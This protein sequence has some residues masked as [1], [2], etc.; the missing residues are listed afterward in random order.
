MNELI[1]TDA[2]LPVR[3]GSSSADA[4]LS[5]CSDIEAVSAWL[6]ARGSRTPNTFDAYKRESG[7]LLLWLKD[8]GLGLRDLKVEHVHEFFQFLAAP[9][10]HWLR[11]RK[12]ERGQQL[13]PTQVMVGPLT[14][15]SIDYARTVLGQMCGYL[16][17]AGY[18]QRNVFRLSS[19][20][21]VVNKS[22]S[23]RS[24]DIESWNWLWSWITRMP[25]EDD[26]EEA[27]AV[28]A[29]WLFALLYHAGIRRD[30]VASGTM[31]DFVRTDGDWQ[32]RVIGKGS[33]ERLVTVN[34]VLLQ[35]LLIY[36]AW[37]GLAP[38][39]PVPS[40]RTPL[41]LSVY[42]ARSAAAMTPRA[43]G[44]IISEVAAEAAKHCADEHI[45]DKIERMS[46]HWM[47]HT[48]ATHR[49]KAGASLQTVQ[50][51][52]GHRDLKTT[53]IYTV[54]IAEARREDAELLARL[55]SGDS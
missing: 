37:H 22:V 28:R 6:L 38:A 48:S 21:A 16:Q 24:L 25:R 26:R 54:D 33:R 27:R 55:H 49:L 19:K 18:V 35:E 32:L 46:T 52:L 5:A 31:G 10:Q 1:D 3:T 23:S 11:P 44:K 14:A 45:R 17:D 15:S 20:P 40:E 51:E 4:A 9:P 2:S 7:R 30:E 47:R 42:A 53:R 29:R 50:D 39:Y 8:R 12:I 41:V 13:A 43:V 34:S 36:R